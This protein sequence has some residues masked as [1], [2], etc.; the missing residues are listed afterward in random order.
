MRW[1]LKK[2]AMLL[3][4]CFVL[5]PVLVMGITSNLVAR[6]IVEGKTSDLSAKTMEKLSQYISRDMQYL[7]E[8]ATSYTK[9]T[10]LIGYL[11]E[12]ENEEA[13]R[14]KLHYKIRTEIT[15]GGN[16]G[17]RISF[18]VSYILLTHQGEVFHMM[19]Y[20]PYGNTE[21]IR[22]NIE[23]EEWY[24][25]L[26]THLYDSQWIGFRP[27]WILGKQGEEQLVFSS[28]IT[29]DSKNYGVLVLCIN[30]SYFSK[31]MENFKFSPDSMI[32]LADGKEQ[33]ALPGWGDEQRV[34]ELT[35]EE[36][37]SI[38]EEG[39]ST[40]WSGGTEYSATKAQIRLPNFGPY[41]SMYMLTPLTD[42][43]READVITYVTVGLVLFNLLSVLV[44]VVMVNRSVV[45]P[46]TH[47]SQ[48]MEEVRKGD[49][50][51]RTNID[52]KDEIGQLSEGFNQM[53]AQL[54]KNILQIQEEE[55]Q[56]RQLEVRVLQAQINPHFIRNTLNTVRWMAELKKASGISRAITSF[57]KLMDYSFRDRNDLVTVETE[58][59]YLH[60]YIY[61]Q[62][63]RYQ[64]RFQ[65]EIQVEEH[66]KSVQVLR[67]LLQ[68]IVEN[69]ILHGLEEK[70]GFG[71]LEIRFH[72]EEDMLLIDVRDDGVG[73]TEAKM[74]EV[75]A[76]TVHRAKGGSHI[77]VTNV[78][79]RIKLHY[80]ESYGLT[81]F[82]VPDEGTLVQLRLP[83]LGAPSD[84]E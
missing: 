34:A 54:D 32:L 61:L 38:S 40:V 30:R 28:N 82:S 69:S 46:L 50:T 1:N 2:K 27:N 6:N 18:P 29:H 52:Q 83:L 39:S 57:I 9:S 15:S 33:T 24:A 37:M 56:K 7:S 55:K 63:L 73:M 35:K 44:L 17:M 42:V 72:R 41:W 62:R 4:L 77:G 11:K 76:G 12:L 23:Q 16:H 25:G 65:V 5:F 31:F 21:E 22:Q 80:G 81:I 71:T 66:L 26:S 10:K 79:E 64:N 70:K 78:L 68:P 43:T 59:L 84:A 8:M 74:E 13:D 3:M 48:L 51:V 49:L 53:V 19:S 60:E 67:L 20:S 36:L 14:E 45:N 58:I 75:F 47:L